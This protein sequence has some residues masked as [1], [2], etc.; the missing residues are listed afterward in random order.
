MKKEDKTARTPARTVDAPRRARV[1]ALLNAG[2]TIG[3]A[4]VVVAMAG[5]KVPPY[6]SD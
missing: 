1:A 6:Q 3:A 4:I 2:V 5:P